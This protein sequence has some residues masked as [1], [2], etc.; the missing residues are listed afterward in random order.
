MHQTHLLSLLDVIVF[1]L[2]WPTNKHDLQLPCAMP[3]INIKQV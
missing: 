2:I 3:K 1:A